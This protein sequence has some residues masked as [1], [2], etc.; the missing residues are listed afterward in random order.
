VTLAHPVS[1]HP[2]VDIPLALTAMVAAL[3]VFV[4]AV[5]WPARR[6]P[7]PSGPVEAVPLTAS[8]PGRLSASQV[9]VRALAVALLVVTVAAGRVGLDD[10][11]E[12]IAPALVV[13]V[14]WPLLVLTSAV[15]GPVWRWLDP[16]DG[17]ARVLGREPAVDG[18]YGEPGTVWPATATAFAV[19]WY[20]SAFADP[21]DPRAVGLALALYTVLTVSGC[22]AL[23]RPRWLGSVEALGLVLSWVALLPRR[24]LADWAPPRGAEAVLGVFVGGILF[25]AVRGTGLWARLVGDPADPVTATLGLA[26]FCLVVAAVLAGVAHASEPLQARAGIARAVVPVVVAVSVAVALERYRFTTSL[27][28]LPGLLGDPFGLGWD[29]LGPAVEGLDPTPVTP[30]TLLWL[31]LA[32]LAVGHLAGAVVVA[33]GL[34]DR[35]RLPAALVLVHLTAGSMAAV[36]LH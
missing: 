12:N 22:L 34:R 21:L 1:G 4:V 8:W 2:H 36:A 19:M 10:E 32:V 27:Q 5:A 33:R 25:G 29:P 26:V 11:L 17:T 9:A 24:R 13:G 23:G 35:A 18:R 7:A 14:S 20:V 3:A 28:L 6:R 30:L 31:Q 15:A 16:W